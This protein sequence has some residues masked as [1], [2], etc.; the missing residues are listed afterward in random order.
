[1]A[2]EPTEIPNTRHIPQPTD[3]ENLNGL[4]FIPNTKADGNDFAHLDGKRP[5]VLLGKCSACIPNTGDPILRAI[6]EINRDSSGGNITDADGNE[7]LN[8]EDRFLKELGIM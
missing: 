2:R 1:M 3:Y 7:I 5:N 4:E 8:G 6:E